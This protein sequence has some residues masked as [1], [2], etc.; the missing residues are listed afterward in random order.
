MGKSS[1]GWNRSATSNAGGD[2]HRNRNSLAV[3]FDSDSQP[4]CQ[5]HVTNRRRLASDHVQ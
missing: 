4:V 5:L 2:A 3:P 1:T